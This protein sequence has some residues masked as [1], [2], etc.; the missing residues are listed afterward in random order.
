MLLVNSVCTLIN[1]VIVNSIRVDLVSHA[2]FSRGIV[3]TIL[4]QVKDGLYH[5]Q[6]PTNMFLLFIVKVFGC[7]HQSKWTISSS[8]CQHG[9]GST[10]H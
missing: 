10:G 2:I 3:V 8:M 4:T 9:M 1:V 5:D 7:L 6:F